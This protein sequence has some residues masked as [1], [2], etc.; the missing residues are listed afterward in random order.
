MS[1]RVGGIIGCNDKTSSW[2]L[3]AFKRAPRRQY[4]IGEKPPVILYTYVNRHAGINHLGPHGWRGFSYTIKL[5]CVGVI[6]TRIDWVLTGGGGGMTTPPLQYVSRFDGGGEIVGFGGRGYK[7]SRPWCSLFVGFPSLGVTTPP[8][9]YVSRFDGGGEIVGF[10][11]G[12]YTE[13][14]PRRSLFVGFP[15]LVVAVCTRI[16]SQN[17]HEKYKVTPEVSYMQ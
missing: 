6:G 14:R 13:S 17:V 7:E 9:Q 10:G 8:L 16:S 2:H 11:G 3:M 4:H 12:G 1:K 15:S 5:R